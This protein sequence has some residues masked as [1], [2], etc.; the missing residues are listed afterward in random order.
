MDLAAIRS[1]L[2]TLHREACNF[3]TEVLHKRPT[4][5]LVLRRGP[6]ELLE[7]RLDEYLKKFVALDAELIGHANAPG[8]IN[9]ALRNSAQFGFYTA[10]RDSVRGL[11]TDTSGSLASLRSRLDFL[12][13]LLVSL[14]AVIVAVIA[15]FV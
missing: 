3:L 12:G 4:V 14:V 11:L 8:D 15:L 10:V 1:E 2:T 7:E 6:I 13:S 9:A 5:G